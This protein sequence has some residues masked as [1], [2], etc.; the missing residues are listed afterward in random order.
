LNAEEVFRILFNANQDVPANPPLPIVLASHGCLT[1]IDIVLSG[2]LT[3]NNPIFD[4]KQDAE[5]G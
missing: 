3:R 1:L 4:K 2:S 5:R